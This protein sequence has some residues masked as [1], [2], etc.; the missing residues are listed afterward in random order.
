MK[1]FFT[2]NSS[3]FLGCLLFLLTL[4]PIISLAQEP[5]VYN[6]LE[7]G[8]VQGQ[9]ESENGTVTIVGGSGLDTYFRWA[10]TTFFTI[11]VVIAIVQFTIGGLQYMLSSALS[12]VSDGKKMMW[13]SVYGLL[14]A[15]SSYLILNTINPKLVQWDLTSIG[16]S[17]APATTD[18]QQ[19]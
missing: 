5:A 2:K 19:K 7:P 8:F 6:L 11:L 10:F 15:L 13:R 12:K 16:G 1:K 18:T 9:A 4:I 17:T 3:F 14:I